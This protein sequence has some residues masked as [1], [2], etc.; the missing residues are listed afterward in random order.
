M[1]YNTGNPMPLLIQR[2]EIGEF[3][4]ARTEWNELLERSACDSVFL[5]WE[6]IHTWWDIFKKDRKLFILAA[7]LDGRLVG[8]A[9]LCIDQNSHFGPK[10]LKMCADDVS[11]D[12]MDIFAEPGRESE[13]ARDVAHYITDCAFEWDMIVMDNLRAESPLLSERSLFGDYAVMKQVSQICPYVRIAGSFDGYYKERPELVSYSLPKKLKKLRDEI[14]VI[15]RIVQDE[16]ARAKG[17]ADLFMLHEKRTRATKVR[18]NFLSADTKRFHDALSR[19]FLKE[20]LLNFHLLYSGETAIAARYGFTYKK[21]MFSYQS[22]FDPEW[23]KRSVGAVMVYLVLEDAF[24]N[25]LVEF[26]FLKGAESYK[27]LWSN[28]V[29]DEMRLTVFG[30][31]LRGSCCRLLDN[32]K[33]ALRSAKHAVRGGAPG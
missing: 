27:S 16:G 9:P 31:S 13:V 15:H 30:G 17:L 29:R 22:G 18:S 8:I 10:I 33:S 3:D 23:K 11:P 6:W 32:V 19:F 12:Y 14:Q 21:K 25:R 26:D 4:G 5:R 28:A 1:G 7:R 24:N 20:G 2:L